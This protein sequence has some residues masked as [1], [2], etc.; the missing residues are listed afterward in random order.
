[1]A[2]LPATTLASVLSAVPALDG[3]PLYDSQPRDG[4]TG[5]GVVGVGS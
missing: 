5:G 3:A 2:Y 4:I 1:M